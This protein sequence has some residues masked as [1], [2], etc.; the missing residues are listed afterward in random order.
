MNKC[1]AK[2]GASA[3]DLQGPVSDVA[4]GPD[5][6][7]VLEHTIAK[8]KKAHGL[9]LESE[10]E[11]DHLR[12]EEKM[13]TLSKSGVARRRNAVEKA[14]RHVN[15]A[16][17][18]VMLLLDW[19]LSVQEKARPGTWSSSSDALAF[20]GALF[21]LKQGQRVARAGWNG[22]GMWLKLVTADEWYLYTGD[23]EC[24]GD[25]RGLP[26]I[27][28]KTVDGGFVPWLASQTDMLAEDW[29]VVS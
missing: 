10:R 1:E 7:V 12:L 2:Q 29:A 8:L 13:G 19:C 3:P 23:I 28:M 24:Y 11:R 4:P 15:H 6:L 26:W 25:V 18:V 16:S 21:A 14:D 20:G 5:A 17:G 27:G 22:R 9:L